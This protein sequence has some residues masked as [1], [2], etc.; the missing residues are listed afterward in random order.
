MGW[1]FLQILEP[2]KQQMEK[3]LHQVV[4]AAFKAGATAK[5][6]DTAAIYQNEESVVSYYI[7]V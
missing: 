1:R 2:W 5:H 6:I 7:M 4:L 3:K